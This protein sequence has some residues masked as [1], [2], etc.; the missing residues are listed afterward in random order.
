MLNETSDINII[1]NQD[2]QM[3]IQR[4]WGKAMLP[5]EYDWRMNKR[6]DAALANAY[7][8]MGDIWALKMIEV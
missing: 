3:A 7:D 5:L 8:L 1:L 2:T 4:Y 6:S